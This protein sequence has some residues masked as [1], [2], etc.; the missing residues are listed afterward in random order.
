MRD[1]DDVEADEPEPEPEPEPDPEPDSPSNSSQ[2]S[3]ISPSRR[4]SR[5][6]PEVLLTSPSPQR[7][8]SNT[9]L[10]SISHP[11]VRPEALTAS[12]YD[13]VPTMAA[14]HATS[15]NAVTATPDMRWVFS[16]G[17][18]GYIRK[19]NWVDTVNGKLMLTVAQRHPFVDSVTKAGVMMTYWENF[20]PASE[21]ISRRSLCMLQLI[22]CSET[23]GLWICQHGPRAVSSLLSCDSKSRDLAVIR[24]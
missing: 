13:I 10:D 15:I 8:P 24:S 18:D 4:P 11:P 16:G 1:V 19:F 9:L 6:N 22:I 2:G 3:E 20:E 17:H 21:S 12:T 7:S 5:P 14:P 23:I